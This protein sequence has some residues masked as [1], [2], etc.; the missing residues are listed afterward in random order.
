MDTTTLSIAIRNLS[1]SAQRQGLGYRHD[2]DTLFKAV[3]D[4]YIARLAGVSASM[5]EKIKNLINSK[6]PNALQD[7]IDQEKKALLEAE[8]KKFFDD[9]KTKVLMESELDRRILQKQA[10]R[11]Q[12]LQLKQRILEDIHQAHF[13]QLGIPF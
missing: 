5:L 11:I 9:P 6:D 8:V 4:P 3:E 1:V 13:N 2:P 7:A 12:D 10:G